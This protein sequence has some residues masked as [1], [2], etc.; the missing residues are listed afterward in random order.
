MRLLFTM[1]W[2]LLHSWWQADRI[3]ISPGAGQLLRLE[4]PCWLYLD[5]QYVEVVDRTVCAGQQQVIYGCRTR[6]G[7]G[8]LVVDLVKTDLTAQWLEGDKVVWLAAADV[9]VF[10]RQ[11]N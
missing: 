6:T 7:V 5:G 10:A 11:W 9:E 1:A 2:R 3:R 8:N 4:P